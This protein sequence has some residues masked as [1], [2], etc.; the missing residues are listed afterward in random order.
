MPSSVATARL[1][2]TALVVLTLF[3]WASVP[4]FLKY[5]TPYID[6]WEANGWRYGI[7]ALLWLPYVAT[8]HRRG[9]SRSEGRSI[10]RSA[11]VPAAFNTVGQVCF[12]LA[13]YYLEPGFMSFVF[14]IQVVF[15]TL[16]A[17]LLFPAER[18][19]LRS[20]VYWLG[21]AGVCAGAIGT[22]AFGPGIPRGATAAGIAIALTSGVM[23]AG[24]ALSVRYFMTGFGS[25]GAF[26]VISN[27]TAVAMVTLMLLVGRSR[28]ADVL[29]FAPGQWGMLVASALIGIAISH[30]LYYAALARLG[31][32]V[33]VGILQ[34]QP[35]LTAAA[36]AAIF[37]E[38]LAPLQWVSGGVAVA[39]A[40]LMLSVRRPP[41]VEDAAPGSQATAAAS[42]R[43]SAMA[44]SSNGARKPSST[45]AAARG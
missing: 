36:S 44:S 9:G 15:V 34:I 23:F 41:P 17:Y 31:V 2:G 28:G 8:L 10:W 5:F 35:F 19:T 37:H 21:L 11:A 40:I 13:P 30:V 4:L 20:P 27:Y 16:G 38:R 18:G 12:A 33:S 42:G 45:R 24:Y 1:T 43:T 29:A 32:A 7:S 25:V 6:A 3:A 26:G 39:G 22:I 14:R